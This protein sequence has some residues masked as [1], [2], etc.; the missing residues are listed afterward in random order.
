[1]C[2]AFGVFVSGVAHFIDN[3]IDRI[4]IRFHLEESNSDDESDY[5]PPPYSA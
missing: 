4:D 3:A 1:M 5:P 2:F